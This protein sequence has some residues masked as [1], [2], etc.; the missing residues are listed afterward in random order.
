MKN[1]EYCEKEFHPSYDSQRFCSNLCANKSR[2]GKKFT[3]SS[4]SKEKISD[5]VKKRWKDDKFKHVDWIK[6]GA[7][8]SSGKYKKP[9]NLFEV[10]SRT[11]SKILSR[12]IQYENLG[13][14]LC[15]WNEGIG[16]MH[17]ING[18]KVEDP[19][20]H[21]NITYL[22]PNCHRL[23]HTHKIDKSKLISL[24]VQLGS[25]WEKYY[26]G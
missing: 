22:C 17:H 19:D 4:T 16:D 1:C 23:V 21:N 13:C 8:G 11:M 5:I 25:A 9:S 20:N 14:S 18:R 3:L 2:K 10:S 24:S 12:L 6:S 15:G 7:K 26:Y